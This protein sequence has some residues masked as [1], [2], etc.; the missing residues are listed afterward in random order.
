MEELVEPVLHEYEP[1]APAPEAVRVTLAPAQIAPGLL[2]EAVGGELTV[3]VLEAVAVHPLLSVAV[4]LYVVVEAG[5]TVM[6]ELVEPLLHEYEPPAPAPE[7]VSV[8]LA[9]E[10]TAPGLLIEA[11]GGELTVTVREAV[12]VQPLLSVAVTL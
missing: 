3:T 2:I 11:V 7:A 8:T 4:T 9:P 12:A 6:E 5:E 10:Q 1:P